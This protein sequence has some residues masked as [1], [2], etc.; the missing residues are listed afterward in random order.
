MD[1]ESFKKFHQCYPDTAPLA[2][3]IVF[4][5]HLAEEKRQ[6]D[7]SDKDKEDEI[8]KI[9]TPGS[10]GAIRKRNLPAQKNQ[11]QIS[12]GCPGQGLFG[13]IDSTNV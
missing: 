6:V 7:K 5:F 2:L 8:E 13:N 1:F 4:V 12:I 11:N 10:Q 3:Y 9:L